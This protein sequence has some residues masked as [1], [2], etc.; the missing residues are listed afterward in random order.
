MPEVLVERI[1]KLRSSEARRLKQRLARFVR[2]LLDIYNI[3]DWQELGLG[4]LDE[5][6]IYKWALEYCHGLTLGEC[7]DRLEQEVAKHGMKETTRRTKKYIMEELK[8]YEAQAQLYHN[9]SELFGIPIEVDEYTGEMLYRLYKNPEE[10]GKLMRDIV[11]SYLTSLGWPEEE[12]EEIAENSARV[13]EKIASKKNRGVVLAH[14]T[15]I[16]RA[17]TRRGQ[18]A[19]EARSRLAKQLLEQLRKQQAEEYV[20]SLEEITRLVGGRIRK[21]A[22]S[23]T[24]AE[25]ITR[26][27]QIGAREAVVGLRPGE[28][29]WVYPFI[30]ENPICRAVYHPRYNAWIL[31]ECSS[32]VLIVKQK[33]GRLYYYAISKRKRQRVRK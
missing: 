15:Q 28:E 19:Y 23:K 2:R 7:M 14:W 5:E 32:P 11:R 12:A 21:P 25:A 33:G 24:I 31:A 8:R 6:H 30:E 26:L 16:L 22:H 4:G 10:D 29:A 20:G 13:L 9:L 1:E 18:V 27:E 17:A 3:E